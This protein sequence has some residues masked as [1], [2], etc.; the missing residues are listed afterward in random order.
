LKKN[1]LHN[2]KRLLNLL[3]QGNEHAFTQLY[4]VHKNKVYSDALLITKSQILAEEIVQDV[5]LKL[6]LKRTEMAD[7]NNLESFL[8]TV[9][10]NL[11]FDYLKKISYQVELKENIEYNFNPVIGADFLVRQHQC[12]L[13]LAEAFNK[14][15]P[16]QKIVYQLAKIEGL[17]HEIIAQKLKLSKLTVKKHM[18]NSLRFI[19]QHLNKHLFSVL[20][21]FNQ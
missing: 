13:M 1:T 9:S 10:R 12:Q 11:I 2:E 3:S 6:W 4:S 17:S 8:H 7:I 20:L 5:F 15:H 14:L 18:A 21:F 16:Q 19:R